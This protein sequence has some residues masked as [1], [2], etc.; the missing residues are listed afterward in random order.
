MSVRGIDVSHHQGEVNWFS[1]AT[2]DVKYAFVKATEGNT[3]VDQQ[4]DRN[5]RRIQEAGLLRGAYH[6]GRPG[7][8]PETQAVHFS[9]VVG[10]LGFGD[11]PPVLDLE[12]DDGHGPAHVLEWARAFTRKAE[13]LFGRKLIVYTGAFWRGEMG[14]P[15]DPLFRERALWLAAYVQNPVVPA[16]WKRWTFWQYT[17]GKHNGPVA[18]PGVPPCDQDLFAG[19]ATQLAALCDPGAVPP[20]EPTPVPQPGNAW[21]NI[22][23]VWPRRPTVSGPAVRQWQTRMVEL[24]FTLDIDGAYGP[25]SKAACTAFQRDRGLSADGIV[26]RRTWNACFGL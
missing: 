13:A 8:D 9:S 1:V 17:D 5:W 14:N 24:G 12:E 20:V 19:D 2:S 3:F 25:Q 10:P 4:F 18:I 26:G 23:F 7:R 21:P 6:F 22:A 11:L 15:D 16:S